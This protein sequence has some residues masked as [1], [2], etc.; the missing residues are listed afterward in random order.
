MSTR[1]VSPTVATPVPSI[2]PLHN[3]LLH[4]TCDCGQHTIGGAEC[5]ECRKKGKKTEL[6]SKNY[7][8]AA[9]NYSQCRVIRIARTSLGIR[10]SGSEVQNGTECILQCTLSSDGFAM[11][12]Q[13]ARVMAGLIGRLRN[14]RRQG[15]LMRGRQGLFHFLMRAGARNCVDEAS[16]IGWWG[17]Y[18]RE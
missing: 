3:A 7:G 14:S 10:I 8:A 12:E 16:P 13:T 5:E 2:M 15:E 9:Q 11:T 18:H 4:R 17:T 1:A 6:Q